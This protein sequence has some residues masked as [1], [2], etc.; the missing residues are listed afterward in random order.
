MTF[1]FVFFSIQTELG[2]EY[3]K[4]HVCGARPGDNPPNEPPNGK[5][6]NDFI[7]KTYTQGEVIEIK[8]Q[9]TANHKG[10]ME[11]RICENDEKQAVVDYDC[12]NKNLLVGEDGVT[13]AFKI[14][15]QS[16]SADIAHRVK[17]PPNLTC[18]RCIL[19]WRYRAGNSWAKGCAGTI[20]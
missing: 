15:T 6:A 1:L 16:Y 7:V 11:Y 12:F 20:F 10:E 8:S 5:Y 4:C 17:L 9:L 3:P 2:E 13:T 19:Q 18:K 14:I